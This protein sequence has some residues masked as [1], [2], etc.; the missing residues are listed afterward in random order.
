M[1]EWLQ[2]I[3]ARVLQEMVAIRTQFGVDIFLWVSEFGRPYTIGA[4]TVV[5]VL[6][7]YLKGWYRRAVALMVTTVGTGLT[8]LILKQLI[9]TPRPP[10]SY[11]TYVE[12]TF[13]FPSGHTAGALALYGL[14]AYMLVHAANTRRLKLFYLMIAIAMVFFIAYSRLF[15]GVHYLSDVLGGLIVGTVFLWVGIR[16]LRRKP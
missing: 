9:H 7:C 8:I 3:D 12:N 13:S 5:L 4:L 15:L 14:C 10:I 2:T 11:A 16:I 6:F 1:I